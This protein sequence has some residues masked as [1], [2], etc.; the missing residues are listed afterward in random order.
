MNSVKKSLDYMTNYRGFAILMIVMV[1]CLTCFYNRSNVEYPYLYSFL[2]HSTDLFL[3]ISGFLFE[4]LLYKKY[5]YKSFILKKIRRLI[6][7]YIFWAL[8]ISIA[9]FIIKGEDIKYL[10]YTIFTG[11]G[12]GNDAHWYIPF[13]FTLFALSPAL[14]FLQKKNYYIPSFYQFLFLFL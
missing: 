6:I 7:P 1:H 8:P 13:I 9:L 4:Y 3:F 2:G 11:L 14:T 5:T 12:H 10:L